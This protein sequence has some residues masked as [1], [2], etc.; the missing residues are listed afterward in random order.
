MELPSTQPFVPYDS[1]EYAVA[2]HLGSASF[3]GSG[4][5]LSAPDSD[6][7]HIGRSG[8]FTIEGWIYKA[9]DGSHQSLLS[10]RACRH[11]TNGE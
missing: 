2:D 6:D 3:D 4:D 7:W 9:K 5:Y 8:D 1:Q 10:N 11:R